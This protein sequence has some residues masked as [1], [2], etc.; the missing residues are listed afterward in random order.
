MPPRSSG[1]E[2]VP[3]SHQVGG[4]H[5]IP[6]AVSFKL[7]DTF[8]LALEEQ[9]D[10]ARD[11]APALAIDHEAFDG[12]MGSSGSARGPVGR[13]GEGCSDAAYQVLVEQGRT[14]FLGYSEL[15]PCRGWWA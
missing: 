11:H 2:T 7:Y 10:M 13:R 4:R 3:R 9:E 8:G 1:G 14:K 12:E 6:G 5:T 15:E